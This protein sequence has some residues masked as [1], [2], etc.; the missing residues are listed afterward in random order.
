MFYGESLWYQNS[1]SPRVGVGHTKP[2]KRTYFL[3]MSNGLTCEE[4]PV[5]LESGKKER[6]KGGLPYSLKFSRPF[7]FRAFNFRASNFRASDPFRA[8]L[9]FAHQIHF[10]PL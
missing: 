10:A 9:I 3:L 2:T 4:P 1:V 7:Y 6:R 8:P 5:A